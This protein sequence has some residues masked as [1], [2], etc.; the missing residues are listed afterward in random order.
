MS[1]KV[2][3]LAFSAMLLALCHPASAQQP[4]KAQRI[5]FL[6]PGSEPTYAVWTEA[7]RRGLHEQGYVVGKN[8]FI[9]YRYAHEKPELLP[10]LAAELV[11]LK[12]DVLVA[13]G[14][15]STQVAIRATNTIPIVF[16]ITPDPVLSGFVASLARP[17]GNATGLVN[18]SPEVS[19]KRLELLQEVAPKAVRVAV[20]FNPTNSGSQLSSKIHR[21]RLE[22]WEFSFR[23]SRSQSQ[24]RSTKY[25]E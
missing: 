19:G 17:G 10:E 23:R 7:F 22:P 4:V 6:I 24:N 1:R 14:T 12:V 3:A 18:H 25:L 21:A 2:F 8:I 9:E 13:T 11:N 20:M 15:R 16:P 5:G